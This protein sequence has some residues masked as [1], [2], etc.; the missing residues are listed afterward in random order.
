MKTNIYLKLLQKVPNNAISKIFYIIQFHTTTVLNK[1]QPSSQFSEKIMDKSKDSAILID[2]D[3]ESDPETAEIGFRLNLIES[4]NTQLA[5][6]NNRLYAELETLKQKMKIMTQKY[7]K[8]K[9]EQDSRIADLK[10]HHSTLIADFKQHKIDD[11]QQFEE[12][13]LK[14]SKLQV[15]NSELKAK[16]EELLLFSERNF[17]KK[18]KSDQEKDRDFLID[19]YEKKVDNCKEAYK[20]RLSGLKKESREQLEI[21]DGKIEQFEVRV[22]AIKETKNKE[23]DM[24]QTEIW[25]LKQD[26]KNAISEKSTKCKTSENV[27]EVLEDTEMK[28]RIPT[29]SEACTCDSSKYEYYP[30]SQAELSDLKQQ[31]ADTNDFLKTV[32]EKN[33]TYT[34]YVRVEKSDGSTVSYC[35]KTGDL[36][37]EKVPSRKRQTS[38]QIIKQERNK[39]FRKEMNSLVPPSELKQQK[40]LK[41]RKKP[42]IC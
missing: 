41:K 42:P 4:D 21:K 18:L 38:L 17:I 34:G 35:Q 9:T 36:K 28:S 20:L 3:S 32:L 1:Q 2:S 40:P 29:G 33:L 11:K 10:A 19:K 7:Q 16:N 13:F 14:I 6:E 23:I 31:V 24:L 39:L 12:Q 30:G 37:I 27:F 25:L 15:K 8:V 5:K 26:L 22:K